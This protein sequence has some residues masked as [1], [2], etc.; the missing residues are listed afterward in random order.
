MAEGESYFSYL[1]NVRV[2]SGVTLYIS[3]VKKMNYSI[4]III[5]NNYENPQGFP[6]ADDL[7]VVIKEIAKALGQPKIEVDKE[8][9]V[10][11]KFFWTNV[12]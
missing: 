4:S 6:S 5:G 2:L 12:D 9:P 3:K 7:G 11:Y 10:R 8:D 1:E